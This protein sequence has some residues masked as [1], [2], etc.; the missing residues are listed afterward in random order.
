[1]ERNFGDAQTLRD[2]PNLEIPE[3]CDSVETHR[4][5]YCSQKVRSWK[6]ATNFE[7][8]GKLSA[9]AIISRLK[10]AATN[11]KLLRSMRSINEAVAG[12]EE[13]VEASVV[14]ETKFRTGEE[15]EDD[16]YDY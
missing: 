11:K 16:P 3:N 12:W 6:L 8:A 5:G 4:A 14:A 9:A 7:D 10:N 2:Y 15:A 1:L 13:S